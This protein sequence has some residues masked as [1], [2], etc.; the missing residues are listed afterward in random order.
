MHLKVV[1]G[2]RFTRFLSLFALVGVS[3]TPDPQ[4]GES[5]RRLL[6]KV[7]HYRGPWQLAVNNWP[8]CLSPFAPSKCSK[9]L[10]LARRQAKARCQVRMPFFRSDD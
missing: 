6:D 1:Y 5:K 8:L 3:S 10:S 2:W 9:K 4:S 7:F